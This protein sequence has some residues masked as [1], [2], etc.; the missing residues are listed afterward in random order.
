LD[1]PY[2]RYTLVGT[3]SLL[4]ILKDVDS[5]LLTELLEFALSLR[6]IT[7]GGGSC[8]PYL[9]S[10]KLVHAWWLADMGLVKEAG[11]YCA[12]INQ[13]IKAHSKES[14]YLH[15]HLLAK[16]K[17]LTELCNEYHG[18]KGLG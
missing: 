2:V 8:L 16:V 10:Y 13:C 1:T 14:P 11:R 18:K 4:E 12:A 6:P 7:N 15:Q 5:Y 3:N 17:E 9:Q